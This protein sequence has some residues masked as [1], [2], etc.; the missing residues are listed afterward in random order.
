M[1]Q[2]CIDLL[3]EYFPTT[4]EEVKMDVLWNETAFPFSDPNTPEGEAI[5]RKQLV[6]AAAK[7]VTK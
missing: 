5:M 1:C 7:G 2:K 4:T 3:N 6:A